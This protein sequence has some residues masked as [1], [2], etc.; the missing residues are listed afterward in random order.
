[1]GPSGVMLTWLMCGWA[2]FGAGRDHVKVS[3]VGDS[4]DSGHAGYFRYG[5]RQAEPRPRSASAS[6]GLHMINRSLPN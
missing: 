5:E 2:S 3:T 6:P 1:M 4:I